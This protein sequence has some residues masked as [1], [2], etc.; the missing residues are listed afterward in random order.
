MQPLACFFVLA[1]EHFAAIAFDDLPQLGYPFDIDD[2]CRLQYIR[3]HLHK[4]LRAAG[5]R[6]T[7]GRGSHSSAIA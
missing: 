1:A 4:K 3:S 5:K 2:D 6:A 7:A